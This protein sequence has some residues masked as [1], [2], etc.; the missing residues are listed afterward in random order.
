[1][2]SERRAFDCV[3]IARYK[4][5]PMIRYW[6]L[7][8]VVLFVQSSLLAQR[9]ATE[10]ARPIPEIQ[11]LLIISVDG[12]RPDVLL[13]SDAPHVRDL[14]TSG[15]FTFWARTTAV[16][17]TLPSHT[18]MLTGV[19][20]TRHGIEWNRD[21]DFATPVYPRVPTLFELA[22]QSGYSTAM[23]T[24]KTKFDFLD[25]PGTIDFTWFPPPKPAVAATSPSGTNSTLD[26]SVADHAI[27]IL[28]AHKPDL[29][30]VHFPNVD[31][32]GH[33]KG[34]GTP[35]QIAAVH[36]MDEQLARVL[37]ALDDLQLRANTAII[38]SADHGGAGLTHG[39]DDPRSRHIPWM[40]TGPGI[41]KNLDLTLYPELNVNTEDT[42]ATACYL[43]A[44]PI[45]RKIDGKA[46][47]E[48]LEN[49]QLLNTH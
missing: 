12:L 33:A 29:M 21:L 17:T 11:H 45:K 35:Q 18:S 8:V 25:K 40:I 48:V 28:R 7:F 46:V 43:F 39:P 5:V 27:E 31:V 26:K 1:V 38:L 23:V 19:I 10:P 42:F 36:E 37:S 41:R 30:F 20:P 22:K 16:S 34:W 49:Q 47:M 15:S 6:T 2:S 44:I 14:Y 32:V 13:R 4:P 3:A 9:A 24:G